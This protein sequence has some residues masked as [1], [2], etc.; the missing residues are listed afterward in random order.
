MTAVAFVASDAND[1]YLW[2]LVEQIVTHSTVLQNTVYL[3]NLQL[4]YAVDS[5]LSVTALYS[6]IEGNGTINSLYVSKKK[7]RNHFQKVA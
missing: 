7:K 6:L 3:P 5:K 4:C 2:S 1:Q